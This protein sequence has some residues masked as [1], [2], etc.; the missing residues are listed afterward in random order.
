M[1]NNKPI[2]IE[3]TNF[4]EEPLPS[5]RKLLHLIFKQ[6]FGNYHYRWTP[7]W[8]GDY[9]VEKLFFKAL[10]I[11]E[12]NDYEG[13]WS[14]E[15]RQASKE[16]PSLDE[17]RLPVKIRVGELI[18]PFDTDPSHYQVAVEII[19]DGKP[20]SRDAWDGESY[21]CI[22]E[23]RIPFSALCSF[24]PEIV[25]PDTLETV[26]QPYEWDGDGNPLRC[27]DIGVRFYMFTFA[28]EE[29]AKYQVIGRELAFKLRSFIRKCLSDHK[30]LKM[31]FEEI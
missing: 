4:N 30:S 20:V 12:W 28:G 5:G 21:I 13:V 26:T 2:N 24:L 8:K 29:K 17:I 31:G 18:G 27:E 11:E 16:V 1:A 25:I 19:T 14:K 23:T 10:E 9:G 7:P 3:L 6:K 22:G 15:L